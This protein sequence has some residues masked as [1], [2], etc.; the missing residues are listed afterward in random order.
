MALPIVYFF[1]PSEA[2]TEGQVGSP[3]AGLP[4]VSPVGATLL[5]RQR[6]RRCA[7]MTRASTRAHL[8]RA[9]GRTITQLVDYVV[10]MINNSCDILI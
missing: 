8:A 6:L 10:K 5:A 9:S 7:M 4:V 2:P 1:C 3:P